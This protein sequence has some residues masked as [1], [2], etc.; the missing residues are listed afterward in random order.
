MRAT[1]MRYQADL[2][3]RGQLTTVPPNMRIKV[4]GGPRS[5]PVDVETIKADIQQALFE[6]QQRRSINKI[7]CEEKD[8]DG[9]SLELSFRET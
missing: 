2:K 3:A 8:F 9:H 1:F 6:D 5:I 7:D 4:K